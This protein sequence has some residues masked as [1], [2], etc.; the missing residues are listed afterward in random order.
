MLTVNAVYRL[1]VL[2]KKHG[3]GKLSNG[4]VL[5]KLIGTLADNENSDKMIRYSLALDANDPIK[6]NR[7]SDKFIQNRIHYPF[8]GESLGMSMERFQELVQSDTPNFRE[9]LRYLN[10]MSGFCKAV[11][12]PPKIPALTHTILTMMQSDDSLRSIFYN[13]K[14]IPKDDFIG[15]AA[16][17]KQICV[18]ALLI[19][20]WYHVHTAH[21]LGNAKQLTLLEL[22]EKPLFSAFLITD[23][24]SDLLKQNKAYLEQLLRLDQPVTLTEQL[25]EISPEIENNTIFYPLEICYQDQVNPTNQLLSLTQNSLFL[26]AD[27]AMGKST[28]LRTQKGFYLP[29]GTYKKEIR[30]HLLP[31]VSCW[32]LSSILLKYRYQNA[33]FTVESCIAC[34]GENAVLHDLTELYSILSRPMKPAQYLIMLDGTNE[35]DSDLTEPFAE[36]LAYCMKHWKNVRFVLAGRTIPDYPIYDTFERVQLLGIPDTARDEALA[37]LSEIPTDQKLLELLRS[38]LFL[39]HYLDENSENIRTRGEILDTYFQN[40]KSPVTDNSKLLLFAVRFV[41]PFAS[42]AM[43]HHHNTL[44]RADLLDA[45]DAAKSLYLD[46]ECIYQNCIAPL[47]FRKID[48]LNTMQ[49]ADLASLL[50]DHT[51]LLEHDADGGLRFTHQYYR[52]YFAAKYILNSIEALVKGIGSHNPQ[53]QHRLFTQFGLAEVWYYGDEIDEIY[54]L[55]GEICG[56]DRNIPD[57]TGLFYQETL[58]DDLLDMAREFPHFRVVENVMKVM[59][60]ARNGHVCGVDF[61]GLNLPFTMPEGTY[62]SDHGLYPC[63]FRNASVLGVFA[64]S[65][66]ENGDVEQTVYPSKNCE[67]YYLN[68]DFAGAIF[69][70]EENRKILTRYGA[71]L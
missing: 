36:E 54:R 46:N 53:E 21:A 66:P 6:L 48:L 26:Q 34:E 11:L 37:K 20:V 49:N 44:S 32:I 12:D 19:G 63:N 50:I 17:T 51:G 52:D 60:L 31:G 67:K 59:H 16:H 71:I 55:I 61:S 42:N 14:M 27:G 15:S 2:S 25:R 43:L 65:I 38:P 3:K 45:L 9:Y 23:K 7:Y 58:L 29:L 68:C 69:L 5:T 33:Y 64:S 47:H 28:L 10:R 35:I 30:E 56:D 4:E 22:P 40:W 62:F 57:E 41:L 70:V 39:T 13:C 24:T 18:E 1:I 8:Y